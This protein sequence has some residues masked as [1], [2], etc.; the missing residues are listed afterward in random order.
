MR[1]DCADFPPDLSCASEREIL[2][3]RAFFRKVRVGCQ[4]RQ[5]LRTPA[6][7]SGG[8]DLFST[9]FTYLLYL[10]YLLGRARQVGREIGA[11]E[12]H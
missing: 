5:V 9:Y 6:L 8:S 2:R 11:L 10:L 4:I 1:L 7:Q 3:K 12:S